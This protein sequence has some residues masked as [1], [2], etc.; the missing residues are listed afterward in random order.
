LSGRL[1]LAPHGP[2]GVRGELPAPGDY[3]H[4]RG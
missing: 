3:D 1:R 4:G 2:P